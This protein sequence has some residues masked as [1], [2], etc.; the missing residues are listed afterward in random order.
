MKHDERASA[1]GLPDE[2]EE[3]IKAFMTL[4]NKNKET[5]II[6]CTNDYPQ[7]H[8]QAIK[9]MIK[10]NPVKNFEEQSTYLFALTD[11]NAK[12]SGIDYYG[13]LVSIL[14]NALDVQA[15]GSQSCIDTSWMLQRNLFNAPEA[16]AHPGSNI[17]ASP[18]LLGHM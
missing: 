12:E 15:L 2:K 8:M 3:Q 5:N 13:F 1:V 16:L 6:Y 10:V 17:K 4:L 11:A 9:Q 18:Q 7:E 14:L